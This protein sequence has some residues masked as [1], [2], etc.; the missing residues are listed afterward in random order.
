[1]DKKNF[2]N[3][4]LKTKYGKGLK[5]NIIYDL[6]NNVGE[7]TYLN[8]QYQWLDIDYIVDFLNKELPSGICELYPE[9]LHT[10]E[11][12]SILRVKQNESSSI[13]NRTAQRL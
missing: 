4:L 11:L 10:K 3:A 1:M 6:L 5:K 13:N 9:P 12:V 2:F 7:Y 8:S